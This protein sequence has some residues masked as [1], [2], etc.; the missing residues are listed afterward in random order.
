LIAVSDTGVPV[1][2]ANPKPKNISFVRAVAA[3]WTQA[4]VTDI[5][6]KNVL[7]GKDQYTVAIL[8]GCRINP[9]DS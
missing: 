4:F 7:I 1:R 2:S 5:G 6:A 8:S 3:N 9:E